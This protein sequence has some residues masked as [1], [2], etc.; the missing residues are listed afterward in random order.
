[1]V[2]LQSFTA[3]RLAIVAGKGGVG[4]TTV[5]AALARAAADRGLRVLV[6]DVDGRPGVVDLLGVP[7][8]GTPDRTLGYEERL[9]VGGLGPD[10]TGRIRGRSLQAPA[11]LVEYLDTHGMRRISK[12]LVSTGV[13]DVVSTAAPGID[14]LL[15]LGK[16]KAIE[17]SGDHDFIVVDGP[18]AGHA[19]TFLMAPAGLRDAIGTGPVNTQAAEVLEMLQDPARCQVILVTIPEETPVNETIETAFALEDRVGVQLAPLV[20]NAFDRAGLDVPDPASAD[21]DGEPHAATLAAAAQFRRGRA[22]D[23][24]D[25]VARL[26]TSLPLPQVHLPTVFAA[27]LAPEDILT[28]AKALDDGGA[29]A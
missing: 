11:A 22:A 23:Q 29:V 16:I 9:L 13:V 7:S 27:G 2:P 18:A 21:L 6:I 25:Q 19:I 12:R 24:S 10:G 26:S 28:L 3:S 15:V 14:D 1:M 5:T 20:I 17:R 4:K 8:S